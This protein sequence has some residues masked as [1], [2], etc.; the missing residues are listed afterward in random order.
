M[1]DK[2]PIRVNLKR[3]VDDYLLNNSV[4]GVPLVQE[5]LAAELGIHPSSLSAII[6]GR[7]RPGPERMAKIA[8]ALKCEIEDIFPGEQ[9]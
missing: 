2:T 8:E 1:A 5:H 4:G 9:P 6:R 7:V 3:A